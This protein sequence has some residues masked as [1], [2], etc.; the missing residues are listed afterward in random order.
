MKKPV[1]S[2]AR[3]PPAAGVAPWAAPG[4]RDVETVSYGGCETSG[5]WA[6]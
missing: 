5:P 4:A 6:V 3:V 1:P 2:P